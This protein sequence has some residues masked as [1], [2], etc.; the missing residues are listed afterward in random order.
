MAIK[1]TIGYMPAVESVNRKFALRREKVNGKVDGIKCFMGGMTRTV[2]YG[3]VGAVSK[4]FMFFRKHAISV[5]ATASQISVRERFTQTVECANHI[6]TD[7][8]QMSAVKALYKGSV[9]DPSKTVQGFTAYGESYRGWVWKVCNK[10][11][12]NGEEVAVVKTFP[13][14][15]DA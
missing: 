10:R 13:T 7:L 1:A 3:G 6:M 15:Y 5:P 4:N 8:T 2:Y 14:S 9:A 12:A 11:L